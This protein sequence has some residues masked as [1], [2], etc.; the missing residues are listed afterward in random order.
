MIEIPHDFSTTLIELF[1]THLG[2]D[3]CISGKKKQTNRFTK[4]TY[5]KVALIDNAAGQQ[6][7]TLHMNIA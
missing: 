2:S 6:W 3:L 4:I 7:P 5:D 1:A